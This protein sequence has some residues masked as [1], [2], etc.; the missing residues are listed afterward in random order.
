MCWDCSGCQKGDR[1]FSVVGCQPSNVNQHWVV[2]P[3]GGDGWATIGVFSGA[4]AASLC[5]TAHGDGRAELL[6]EQCNSSDIDQ[7]WQTPS[8]ATAGAAITS[9]RFP[10][11]CV[12]ASPVDFSGVDGGFLLWPRPQLV[13]VSDNATSLCVSPHLAFTGVPTTGGAGI[14][15]RA[16]A[17]YTAMILPNASALTEAASDDRCLSALALRC[18]GA[19]ASCNDD[20]KLGEDMDESYTLTI[21]I[22]NAA[23]TPKATLEATSVWGLLRGLETFSQMVEQNYSAVDTTLVVRAAPVRVSDR[24]RWSYRG[25]LIDTARHFM[26]LSLLRQHLD[27]MSYSKLNVL[28]WHHHDSG[29]WSL[30]S[31]SI[32]ELSRAATAPGWQYS[33]AE[34]RA[35]VAYA[36]DRGIRVIPEFGE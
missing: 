6:L 27:A 34:V 7:H 3:V 5:V 25:L 20:A 19:T 32:P 30:K 28:H 17:R 29:V 12:D 4:A 23:P 31:A 9:R 10:G 13:E 14:L 24:P 1:L 2:T 36:R 16:V 26:P 33:H 15:R 18:T 11:R 21:G 22:P 35:L 8:A